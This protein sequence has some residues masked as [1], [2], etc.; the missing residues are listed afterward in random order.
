MRRKIPVLLILVLIMSLTSPVFADYDEKIG[1]HWAKDILDVNFLTCHFSYLTRE[2]FKKFNPDADISQY[3]FTL[4]FSSLLKDKGFS[5]VDLGQTRAINRIDAVKIVGNKLISLGVL[6]ADGSTEL[7]FEDTGSLNEEYR[8]ALEI[9]YGSG[10]IYGKSSTEFAPYA[11]LTQAE[12]IVV[13]QRVNNIVDEFI[14]R[15]TE[16]MIPF[17]LS[18]IVQSYSGKEGIIT[19]V[20]E[21]QVVVTITKMFPTPGYSMEVEKIVE[22]NGKY[23]IYLNITPPDENSMLPQVITYKTITITIDREHLKYAPYEFIWGNFL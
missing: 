16:L 3:E 12:A 6:K 17:T 2:D 19:Q 1:N 21:D 18:G 20:K 14:K 23:K 22:D 5:T 11:N 9:L 13:L 7:P 10:I 4:S 8:I 15:E